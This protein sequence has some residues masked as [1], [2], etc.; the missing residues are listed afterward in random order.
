MHGVGYELE[1]ADGPVRRNAWTTRMP[2]F[3]R[4]RAICRIPVSALR[5]TLQA[6][7]RFHRLWIIWHLVPSNPERAWNEWLFCS[8]ASSTSIQVL[9]FMSTANIPGVRTRILTYATAWLH[10]GWTPRN[11]DYR[12]PILTRYKRLSPY[13]TIP[14]QLQHC[15][16]GG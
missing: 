13:S 9:R 14:L 10:K 2:D 3:T 12:R 16:D 15:S 6:Q 4:A 8:Y 1:L 7:T 5:R 11:H